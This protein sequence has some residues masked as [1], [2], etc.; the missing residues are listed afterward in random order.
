MIKL[1][2][3][4]FNE[5]LKLNTG[6]KC[7]GSFNK[8]KGGEQFAI[9]IECLLKIM[10]WNAVNEIGCFR[11]SDCILP[12]VA[13]YKLSEIHT[14]LDKNQPYL[15]EIGAIA[16]EYDICLSFHANA[17]NLARFNEDMYKRMMF[18]AMFLDKTLAKNI[19]IITHLG[20]KETPVSTRIALRD[21]APVIKSKLAIENDNSWSPER[22]IKLARAT[23]VKMV[24]DIFH[25]KCYDYLGMPFN[26]DT[27]NEMLLNAK[28]TWGRKT[29]KYHISSQAVGKCKGTHSKYIDFLDYAYLRRRLKDIGITE[30]NIMLEAGMNDKAVFDLR[31]KTKLEN[32]KWAERWE[33]K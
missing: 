31:Y 27:V 6:H 26:K 19:A 17:I 18:Y 25:H 14:L 8:Q 11:I 9:N 28:K 16:N 23:H 12:R 15:V 7:T 33:L 3:T 32:A 1:G 21:L 22:V 24:Y 10:G 4:F 20:S 30:A 5:T 29:P 13:Q 2:Y